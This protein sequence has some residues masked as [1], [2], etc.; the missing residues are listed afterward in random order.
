VALKIDYKGAWDCPEGVRVK[1]L[2]LERAKGGLPLC[3]RNPLPPRNRGR[4][5]PVLI[6]LPGHSDAP[7][8]SPPFR[9]CNA[10]LSSYQLP[11]SGF[12]QM[13]SSPA[14]SSGF[15]LAPLPVPHG[16]KKPNCQGL[17][18]RSGVPLFT[19]LPGE[20][21]YSRKPVC[22]RSEP[23]CLMTWEKH[24][25]RPARRGSRG[26]LLHVRTDIHPSNSRRHKPFERSAF[27]SDE[28]HWAKTSSITLDTSSYVGEW[29]TRIVPSRAAAT[30]TE[31][32]E[33]PD[34]GVKVSTLLVGSTPEPIAPE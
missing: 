31:T 18:I 26:T 22:S 8:S 33:P 32:G 24:H 1:S 10:R 19:E 6:C 14:M 34:G 5:L 30:T 4:Y 3:T 7:M 25:P 28:R 29:R 20:T 17:R 11:S 27:S 2:C 15:Q 9:I 12:R 21:V 16:R 23:L 13:V